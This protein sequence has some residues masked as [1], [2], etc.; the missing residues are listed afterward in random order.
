LF[1]TFA[2]T[3]KRVATN[4]TLLAAS[5]LLAK[6]LLALPLSPPTVN[7]GLQFRIHKGGAT[8]EDLQLGYVVADGRRW[9]WTLVCGLNFEI[10][11]SPNHPLEPDYRSGKPGTARSYDRHREK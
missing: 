10:V 9:F 5:I 3:A 11:N 4:V 2:D 8:A 6:V 1:R 7:A